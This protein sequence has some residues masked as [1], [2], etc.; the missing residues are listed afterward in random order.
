MLSVTVFEAAVTNMQ[1]SKEVHEERAFYME[2][3]KFHQEN[4]FSQGQVK[5]FLFRKKEL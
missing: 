2:G 3:L 1:S 4:C 5:F